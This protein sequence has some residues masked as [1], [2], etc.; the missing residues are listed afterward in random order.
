MKL[1]L[2]LLDASS[3]LAVSTKNAEDI[4]PAKTMRLK[5]SGRSRSC[6]EE[7]A[8]AF[9]VGTQRFRQRR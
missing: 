5:G 3:T 9:F 8:S 7:W 4:A 2:P 6:K 1:Q